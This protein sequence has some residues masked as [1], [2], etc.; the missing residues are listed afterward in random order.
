M[1]LLT[2][3][4]ELRLTQKKKVR[5]KKSKTKVS[6]KIFRKIKKF[7]QSFIEESAPPKE[8]RPYLGP[9][10]T[11]EQIEEGKF[12]NTRANLKKY[13]APKKKKESEPKYKLKDL[14]S[15]FKVDKSERKKKKQKKKAKRK[16]TRQQNKVKRIEFIRRFVPSYKKSSVISLEFSQEDVPEEKDKQKFRGYLTY[17]INSTVLYLLAYLIVYLTYQITVL[18]VAS[19]WKLDSVLFYYD[20]AFNDLSPLW[21]RINIILTTVSGPMISLLIGILF[22]RFFTTRA[23]IKKSVKLFFLWI[24]LHGYNLF[25][26]AFASGVSFDEGFGYVPAWLYFNVFWQILTALLFLFFLGLIGYYTASKFLDTSF[27]STRIKQ[28]SKFKFLVYQV[29]IPWFAGGLLIFL[30]KIP[31]NMPYDTAN[32]ITMAFAVLPIV[33]NK[34]AKPTKNFRIQKKPSKLNYYMLGVLIIVLL[35]YR[36]GL[37]N[38][39]HIELYYKLLF[40]LEITPL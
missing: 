11:D 21:S 25:L 23:K 10:A 2:K 32:L 17:S 28:K 14:F 35:L 8:Y 34:R 39:L 19:R 24:G 5:Y 15:L 6:G 37:Y 3:I 4:S 18:I 13:T 36:I 16:K 20:L 40:N 38:G 22:L 12:E 27:S 9:E 33:F 31:N 7:F 29:L 26:G 30:I 1:P